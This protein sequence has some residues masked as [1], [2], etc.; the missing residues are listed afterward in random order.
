MDIGQWFEK[1]MA[2]SDDR[3][4]EILYGSRN[5]DEL[6]SSNP[7][8]SKAEWIDLGLDW[9]RERGIIPAKEE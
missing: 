1:Q 3:Y 2:M 6:L 7:S 8:I 4:L 5:V 9:L